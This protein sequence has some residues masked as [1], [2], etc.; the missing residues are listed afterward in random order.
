MQFCKLTYHRYGYEKKMP[1][2]N[3]RPYSEPYNLNEQSPYIDY[4]EAWEVSGDLSATNAGNYK[5]VYTLLPGYVWDNGTYD[6]IEF[7]WTIEVRRIDDP[8]VTGGGTYSGSAFNSTSTY[9]SIYASKSG[10]ESATNAGTYT[11]TFTL[12][13]SINTCW[14]DDT[15]TNINKTWQ[16]S[17]ASGRVSTAPTNRNPALSGSNQN[18]ANA[19]S[20]TGTMY[21]RLGTSGN[22]NTSIPQ[23]SLPGS[24]TLYYYAAESTNYTQSSTGSV[25][26]TAYGASITW[27]L[28]PA[29]SGNP[30]WRKY[31]CSYG[32]TFAN[33]NN[34]SWGWEG[35][36]WWF[37]PN[38]NKWTANTSG[39]YIKG[40]VNASY[41]DYTQTVYLRSGST[42]GAKL[43]STNR[44]ASGATYYANT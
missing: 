27:T 2:P 35:G 7:N 8:I 42:S 31:T 37:A 28:I 38:A 34:W 36:G 41:E 10:V 32:D 15:V 39:V 14:Y 25:T 26:V 40:K 5:I 11:V 33:I 23:V 44:P 16:I 4:N 30:A 20:G 19:G 21:Y 6:P 43:I 18:V 1:Y 29:G 9:D 3:I 22:F 24:W 13:D 12:N 17:K